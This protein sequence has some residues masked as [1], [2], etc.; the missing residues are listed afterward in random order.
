MCVCV[1]CVYMCVCVCVQPDGPEVVEAWKD[2]VHTSSVMPW[3]AVYCRRV[4]GTEPIGT[5]QVDCQHTTATMHDGRQMRRDR[6]GSWGEVLRV[7]TGMTALRW[8]TRRDG[9]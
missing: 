8:S 7:I 9:C 2:A 6:G 1:A 4:T 5:R 3:I